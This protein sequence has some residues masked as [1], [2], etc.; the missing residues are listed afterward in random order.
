MCNFVKKF[1]CEIS[2][3]KFIPLTPLYNILHANL[4]GTLITLIFISIDV[5]MNIFGCT[6]NCMMHGF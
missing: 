3:L 1:L 5:I 6:I 4:F 2:D